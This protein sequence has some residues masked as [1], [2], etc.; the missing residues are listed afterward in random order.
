MSWNQNWPQFKYDSANTGNAPHVELDLPLELVAAWRFPSQIFASPAV[1]GDKIYIQDAVGH[2]GY[3]N[4]RTKEVV[5]TQK[6]GGLNNRSSPAVK[7]NRVY[8]GSTAGYLAILDA[9]TGGVLKKVDGPGGV[10][11]SPVVTDAAVYFCAWDGVLKK[12]SLAGDIIWTYET[13]G[14]FLT[15]FAISQ[16]EIMI[17]PAGVDNFIHILDQGDSR[18]VLERGNDRRGQ[19]CI[20]SGVSLSEDM[21]YCINMGKYGGFGMLEAR[22]SR[23]INQPQ[24]FCYREWHTQRYCRSVPSIRGCEVYCGDACFRIIPGFS[25]RRQ[26]AS[27]PEYKIKY[28]LFRPT[29]PHFEDPTYT[30]EERGRYD[31]LIKW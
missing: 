17:M 19:S 5:W 14:I 15:E 4:Y 1:V 9:T 20:H 3:F 30:G 22:K 6:L 13:G 29:P 31:R 7:N 16:N 26:F 11:A 21:V 23:L 10:I 18:I 28:D 2:V 25:W 27:K 12:M 8:I 24:G